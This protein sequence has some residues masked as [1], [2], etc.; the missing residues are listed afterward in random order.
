M[1]T[2]TRKTS[3]KPS[4]ILGRL[5]SWVYVANTIADGLNG[6]P[7]SWTDGER[8]AYTEKAKA[9][10]I[11]LV[12]KNW[13]KKIGYRLKKGAKPVGTAYF[14]SPISNTGELY[15]LECQAVKIEEGTK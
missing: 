6:K 1:I 3:I 5:N 8:I 2:T 15:I 14:K 12:T 11:T 13:L 9:M 4:E 10:G 7:F